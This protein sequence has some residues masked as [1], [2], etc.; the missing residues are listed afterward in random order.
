[1]AR[2]QQSCPEIMKQEHTV[3]TTLFRKLG[4][5]GEGGVYR[6]HAVLSKLKFL[7]K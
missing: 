4:G 1:M 7:D 6:A 2:E 5:G 3:N